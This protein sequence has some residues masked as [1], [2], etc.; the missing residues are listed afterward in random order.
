MLE[1]AA[2]PAYSA[3][4]TSPADIAKAAMT[5]L[6]SGHAMDGLKTL[7]AG[8]QQFPGAPQLLQLRA[9]ACWQMG[10]LY[11]A[12][13]SLKAL[14]RAQGVDSPATD[15]MT[16][17][18]CLDLLEFDRA[19]AAL[20]R[21]LAAGTMTPGL[22]K[23]AVRLLTWQ[24]DLPLALDILEQQLGATPDDPELLALAV[25]HDRGISDTRL[26]AA[27]SIADRLADTHASKPR[28]YFALARRADANKA[29]DEAWTLAQKANQLQARQQD[30]KYNADARAAFQTQLKTRAGRAVVLSGTLAPP[31][32]PSGQTMIYLVGA[33]RT[34]SSLLQSILSAAPDVDS[35]GERGAMLP[36]L[37]GL[38]DA[39]NPS[40][41]AD[42]LTQ[43]QQADLSGLKRGG[44]TAPHIVDKTT[45]NFFVLPLLAKAHAGAKCVNVVRRPQDVALSIFMHEFPPAF[46]EA[47]DLQTI[48]ETLSARAE[49][50]LL[51]REAGV[52]MITHNH[53]AFCASPEANG[54]TLAKA[55]ELNWSPDALAPENRNAAVPTFSSGQVRR[56]IKPTPAD[57]WQRFAPFMSLE[58][59]ELLQKVEIAQTP[60]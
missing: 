29:S 3:V 36:Y 22:V 28:L 30:Y 25:T 51:Y 32:A 6:A 59:L 45:H 34:G 31:P 5:Q 49:I 16:A 41:A 55:L 37:N 19:R 60:R 23:T 20:D 50:T 44:F 52:E 42:F 56:P 11:A 24:G 48:A 39:P 7:N 4:M 1:R 14:I 17:Q 26:S 40:P 27:T 43:V 54:K 46:P 33:P 2:L 53:D 8:L 10:D 12:D 9:A 47:C 18:L 13:D 15:L 38:C 58:T 35:A 21:L 57:H